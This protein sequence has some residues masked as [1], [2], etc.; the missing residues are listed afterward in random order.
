MLPSKSASH[1][2]VMMAAMAEGKT[3][4]E[5]PALQDIRARSCRRRSV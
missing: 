2:A 3:Q 1:R 4:L 5:P